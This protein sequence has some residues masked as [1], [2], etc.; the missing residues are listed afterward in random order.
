MPTGAQVD[1]KDSRKRMKW[2]GS[3]VRG[4]AEDCSKR[5]N[6]WLV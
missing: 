6:A 1:A 3:A 2:V 4:S 5:E